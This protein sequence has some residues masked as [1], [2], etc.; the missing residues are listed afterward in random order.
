MTIIRPSIFG[1]SDGIVAAMSTR[2]GGVSGP[3]LD[4]NLS[5]KVGDAPENVRENRRRFFEA[6]G[7]AEASVVLP[8]QEHTDVV[9]YCAGPSSHPACDG[10]VTDGTSVV[11][12][13]TVADCTPVLLFAADRRIIAAVH[14]GWRGTAAGIVSRALGM[15]M[16]RWKCVPSEVKAFV[17]PSAGVCC[18]EV[19]SDVAARFPADC[20][21]PMPGGKFRLDVKRAN[22]VQMLASGMRESHIEVH[23]DCTIHDDRYHSHRR[24]GQASGRMVAVIGMIH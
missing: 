19:G 11:L 15:M 2:A 12:G 20:A 18:Y 17:G 13:V 21:A 1:S 5:Y 9:R 24:D 6:A 14:A 4:L 10:L 7:V 22:V 23:P 8:G 16:E 3:V